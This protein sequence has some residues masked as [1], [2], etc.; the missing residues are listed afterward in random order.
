MSDDGHT[1]NNS[2]STNGG[3]SNALPAKPSDIYTGMAQGEAQQLHSFAGRAFVL[4]SCFLA[5]LTVV[6]DFYAQTHRLPWEVHDWTLGLILSPMGAG[7]WSYIE[8][9]FQ[10]R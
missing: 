5:I 9:K 6:M 7:V 2:S 3:V 8:A 10:R 1:D 4:L